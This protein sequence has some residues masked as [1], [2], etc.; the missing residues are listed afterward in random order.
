MSD[1]RLCGCTAGDYDKFVRP[2]YS[3]ILLL[4]YFKVVQNFGSVTVVATNL[5]MVTHMDW[6]F[7]D[8]NV[9]TFIMVG[10][11]F[12]FALVSGDSARPPARTD[13]VARGKALRAAAYLVWRCK[14][15]GPMSAGADCVGGLK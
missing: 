3:Y 11:S 5:T 8:D 12:L 4:T 2:D 10:S 13:L 15:P 14:M 9:A 6:L 1:G 7:T